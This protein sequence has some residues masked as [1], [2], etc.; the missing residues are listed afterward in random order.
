M[1]T[2]SRLIELQ[3][4]M[5]NNS[6]SSPFVTLARLAYDRDTIINI[7]YDKKIL[8]LKFK[9]D[10][11]CYVILQIIYILFGIM[12]HIYLNVDECKMSNL[13]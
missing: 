5:T 11:V 4:H 3:T 1:Q 12:L 9:S 10:I 2:Q 7:K 8:Y 13:I 6:F